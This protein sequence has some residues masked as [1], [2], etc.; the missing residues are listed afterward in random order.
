MRRGDGKFEICP[1][2]IM[3]SARTIMPSRSPNTRSACVRA[4]RRLYRNIVDT[5]QNLAD[6]FANCPHNYWQKMLTG[7][8]PV[9]EWWEGGILNPIFGLH[10]LSK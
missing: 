8:R 2:E 1:L 5:R 7:P 10:N 6:F 3:P 9:L 4:T